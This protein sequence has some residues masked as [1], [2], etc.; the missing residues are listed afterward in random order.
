V[1]SLAGT[2]TPCR[3]GRV[4]FIAAAHTCSAPRAAVGTTTLAVCVALGT[5]PRRGQQRPRCARNH[6]AP[7]RSPRR[8]LAPMTLRA[9]AT[10][11]TVWRASHPS[12]PAY[13]AALFRR[14]SS[15]PRIFVARPR[16]AGSSGARSTHRW[17]RLAPTVPRVRVAGARL[18]LAQ[19][20][21]SRPVSSRSCGGDGPGT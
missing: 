15:W 17:A 5:W 14:A 19:C 3:F 18:C 4:S 1:S 2:C 20:C 13:A 6:S 9:P 7:F 11:R 21:G 8:F 12:S 16:A 10:P